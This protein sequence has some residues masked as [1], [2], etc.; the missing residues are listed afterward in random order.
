MYRIFLLFIITSLTFIRA[1]FLFAEGC[2]IR[3]DLPT[4]A[5]LIGPVEQCIQA[6]SQ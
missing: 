6:R 2:D 3:S 5:E 4:H 1:E